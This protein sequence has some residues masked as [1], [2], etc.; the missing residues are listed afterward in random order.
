M[1]KEY[2]E[3]LSLVAFPL[4]TRLTLA[5]SPTGRTVTPS[6]AQTFTPVNPLTGTNKIL[7]SLNPFS[8]KNANTCDLICSNRPSSHGGS[9][10]S[11]LFTA[12]IN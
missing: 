9:A 7:F 5:S 2:G 4:S 12:T 6:P 10:A 8:N 3:S 11:N 1:R